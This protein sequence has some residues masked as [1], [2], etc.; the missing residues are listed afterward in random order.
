MVGLGSTPKRA[1]SSGADGADLR[2]GMSF[3]VA[4]LIVAMAPSGQALATTAPGF[5]NAP[6]V[7][8]LAPL[9]ITRLD[10]SNALA[11]AEGDGQTA[12]PTEAQNGMIG[13]PPPPTAAGRGGDGGQAIAGLA[14]PNQ[15][16]PS[17]ISG[18]TG[19]TAN[20]AAAAG[21][22]SI[23]GQDRA[24]GR[25]VA[26]TP[27]SDVD[28][29]QLLSLYPDGAGQ[30]KTSADELDLV[31]NSRQIFTDLRTLETRLNVMQRPTFN[32]V[33]RHST[34]S[35]H[36]DINQLEVSQDLFFSAGKDDLRLGVQRISYDV[37]GPNDV[38]QYAAG[39]T[40]NVRLDDLAAIT[41]E[42]WVNRLDYGGL[43]KNVVTFDTFLTL[44]PSDVIRIDLDTSR[45]IFDNI[46]SLQLGLTAQS[47]GGS[48]DYVPTDQLRLTGRLFGAS[49]SD[50]NRRRSEELEAVWRIRNG[51]PL[52]E[53][54]LRGMNFHFSR[55]LNDGYFNPRDYVSGEAMF[56]VQS[57]LSPKF[58][59]ELAGSGGAEKADPG[60]V[61]PLVK[62]SLQ[63]VYKLSNGWAIDGEASHFTS[64]ESSSSGFSRTTFTLG[65]HYRF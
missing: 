24:N 34:Q 27:S 35:D 10:S 55:L 47:Y 28:P 9:T 20:P 60:G 33:D 50:G 45:R 23:D 7:P 17:I 21:G 4:C 30:A 2:Y 22:S 53:I 38:L 37:P 61:K 40:G 19:D 58:T 41:G 52:F 31:L 42:L 25:L 26:Y 56:R 59:V 63:A 13:E 29:D 16:T 51:G 36:L 11:E 14:T 65:L 15:A 62:G 12:P 39:F 32:V 46:T 5:P 57:E 49:Y 44:R 54:G 18:S 43:R 1:F 8:L 48:L 64:R 6:A 3:V